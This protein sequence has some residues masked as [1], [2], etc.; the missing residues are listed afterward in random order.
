VTGSVE[1]NLEAIHDGTIT[2]LSGGAFDTVSQIMARMETCAHCGGSGRVEIDGDGTDADCG[3]CCGK[4]V[5]SGCD[6]FCDDCGKELGVIEIRGGVRICEDCERGEFDS[7][8]VMALIDSLR[9]TIIAPLYA[10][11]E[12][13]KRADPP[14]RVTIDT[15]EQIPPSFF[16]LLHCEQ[17]AQKLAFALE[18]LRR[19]LV[20]EENARAPDRRGGGTWKGRGSVR[21]DSG[22]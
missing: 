19:H 6:F 1:T 10:A 8:S 13:A 3:E 18:N 5:E 15:V 17:D 20:Q 4:G 9:H 11:M 22:K 2:S 7:K 21:Q 12:A 14:R 16:Q